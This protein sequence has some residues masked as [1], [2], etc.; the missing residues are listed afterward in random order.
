MSADIL[1]DDNKR[2]DEQIK[3]AEKLRDALLTAWQASVKG[4]AD[5][6]AEAEK[7]LAKAADIR[8]TGADKAAAKTRSVL[9][10]EE[11]QAQIQ[12]EFSKAADSAGEAASLAKFAA[13]HGRVENAAKLAQQAEKDAERAAK[14]ADQIDD[15]QAA[16]QA[17][18]K[19]AE[20]QAQLV[21]AQA[22]AKKKES[23]DLAAQADAQKAKLA[24]IEKQL[25]DLQTKAA[26]IRVEADVA[27]AKTALAGLQAQLENIKD[28]TV[29]VTVNTVNSGATPPDAGPVPAK[30][31]GG[32][33]PGR[34]SHDRADN[35]LYWGTPGEWVVQ[36]P[37]VRYYGPDFMAALNAMR[38]PKYANGGLL[39]NLRVP[40]LSSAAPAPS[41][42]VTFSF[43]GMG[44]FPASMAPDVLGELKTALARESLKRGARA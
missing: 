13:I 21:E 28:K 20:I 1:D 12:S 38:L 17:I 6:S 2:T 43:P 39:G 31:Y 29:T 27:S 3:N 33:L 16:A 41:S 24:E 32:P 42:N 22:A 35:M 8:Q 25:T 44:K 11:Q 34:A 14:F 26:S 10:P 7:L 15:P 40:S 36:R 4:A 30:A 5:A 9:T 19:A 18:Q 37:A 23:Q